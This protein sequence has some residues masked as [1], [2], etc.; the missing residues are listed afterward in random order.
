MADYLAWAKA[1]PAQANYGI[2]A[3]GSALHFAG[4][5]VTRA[6]GLDLKSV[7][8]RGGGPLLQVKADFERWAPVVKAT[9]FTAE[10]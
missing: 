4:M 10:E 3:A 8:Y 5:L 1:N 6:S 9:G 7:P 2:P